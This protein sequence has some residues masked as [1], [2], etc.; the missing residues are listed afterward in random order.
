MFSNG[1]A[2][3]PLGS[4]SREEKLQK[5]RVCPKSKRKWSEAGQY[6]WWGKIERVDSAGDQQLGLQL[7]FLRIEIELS[8]FSVVVHFEKTKTHGISA[9]GPPRAQPPIDEYRKSC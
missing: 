6:E 9:K 5:K 4:D 7:R 1:C 3:G 2:K 8:V